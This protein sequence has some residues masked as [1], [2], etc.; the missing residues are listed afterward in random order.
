MEGNGYMI[1]KKLGILIIALAVTLFAMGCGQTETNNVNDTG[2]TNQE[3]FS[4]G[5]EYTD[6]DVSIDAGMKE[7]NSEYFDETEPED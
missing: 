6:S 2:E 3:S 1:R 5:E 7:E 4:E